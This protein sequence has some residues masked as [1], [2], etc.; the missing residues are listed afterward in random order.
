MYGMCPQEIAPHYSCK[1]VFKYKN[2]ISVLT[3]TYETEDAAGSIAIGDIFHYKSRNWLR[4]VPDLTRS[5]VTKL[6]FGS[7]PQSRASCHCI[8]L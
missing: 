1:H 5:Q 7:C 2:L 6:Q 4:E 8:I 3:I